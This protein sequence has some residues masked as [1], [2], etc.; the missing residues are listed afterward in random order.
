MSKIAIFGATSAIAVATARLWAASG[1]EFF[2]Y[3]RDVEKLEAVC[4]D[5]RTRGATKVEFAV[6]DLSVNADHPALIERALTALGEIDLVL[7]AYGT[8]SN[9]EAC[10]TN[11]ATG[12]EE[13]NGNFVSVASLCSHLANYLESRGRGTLAVISSVA[14][15]RGRKSNY[16]Y[17]AAK[18]GLSIFLSGLRNRLHSK[19][20]SVITLKPGFVDTPMTKDLKKGFLFSSP[21]KVAEG[22]V[23]AVARRA[24]VVYLPW[25]WR[26][27]MLVIKHI[28]EAIFKRLSL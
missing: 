17:G 27:I 2:L 13:L 3:A 1:N 10:Q 7:I 9:Q 11:I 8:L 4:Q 23:Q 19:G 5:L 28:P 21:Q 15:D 26:Y 22:I 6:S 20:I 16:F 12:L 14:G 24:D 25:F 18:G